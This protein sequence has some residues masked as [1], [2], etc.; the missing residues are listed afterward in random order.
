[1]KMRLTEEATIAAMYEDV[2]HG[3][4]HANGAVQTAEAM[5]MISTRARD[6][7]IDRLKAAWDELKIVAVYHG[8]E[9]A[10]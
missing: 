4:A 8:D 1:M 3:L 6:R 9:D 7:F 5:G 10:A 2:V